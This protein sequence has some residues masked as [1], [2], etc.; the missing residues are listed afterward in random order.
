M[1]TSDHRQGKAQQRQSGGTKGAPD[2][3]KKVM[4]AGLVSGSMAL[5][6]LAARRASADIWRAVMR[7]EP[8]TKNV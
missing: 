8:P 2:T 7:A 4:W 6:A 3:V 5:G 1:N